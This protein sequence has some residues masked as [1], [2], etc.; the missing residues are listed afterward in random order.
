M[1]QLL[2]KFFSPLSRTVN[3]AELP[4]V[5]QVGGKNYYYYYYYSYYYYYYYY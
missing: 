3:P 5:C 2:G 1:R 4:C